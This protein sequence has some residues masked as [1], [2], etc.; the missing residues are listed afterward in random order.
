M[1]S[2]EQMSDKRFR[3]RE[4][5]ELGFDEIKITTDAR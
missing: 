3:V 1:T 5:P 2:D 4:L